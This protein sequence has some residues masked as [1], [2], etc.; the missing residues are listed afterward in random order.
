MEEIIA[1]YLAD[2]MSQV[3][4]KEFEKELLSDEQLQEELQESTMAIELGS[5]KNDDNNSFDVESAWLKTSKRITIEKTIT[6]VQPKYSFLKI[7]A[8]L[9]IIA[10]LGYLAIQQTEVF[11][12]EQFEVLSSDNTVKEFELPDGSQLILNANSEISFKDGFGE[13]HRTLTLIGGAN[14]DVERNESLP[15]VII[16][17]NSE[18][19]VLGTSFEVM[20][21]D[22]FPVEVN[23]SSGTVRFKATKTKSEP[24][25]LEA[26][27]MARL[28]AD[29]T[30]LQRGK[31]QNENY[32]AWWTRKLIFEGTPLNE[33]IKDLSKTYWVEFE[34]SENLQN[35]TLDMNV[36]GA[37]LEQALDILQATYPSMTITT[38]KENHIK[39]D[40]KICNN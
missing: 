16:T 9:L 38:D 14:F 10:A 20:A 4:R 29:G 6:P 34:V 1:K 39:L 30:Q 37:T 2:E 32:A 8:T 17:N 3:E 12:N 5:S 25:V 21:Y 13:E 24:V 35:C 11:Q 40:G 26:G 28:S 22:N 31:I 36:D 23:V 33:A 7:A 18:L 19:E 27:Y 15:F